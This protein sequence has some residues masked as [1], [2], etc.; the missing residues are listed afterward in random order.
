MLNLGFSEIFLIMAVA[1]VVIG[2][3]RLPEVLRFMGRQYG[4]LTRASNELR[5]AF[6]MEAERSDIEKRADALRKRREEARKRIADQRERT[7]LAAQEDTSVTP[8]I[9]PVGRTRLPHGH[10]PPIPEADAPA[11]AGQE[12]VAGAIPAS[13]PA[14]TP[15]AAPEVATA[16]PEAASSPTAHG[17]ESE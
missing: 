17:A 2:P 14:Q 11:D 8:E 12:P 10:M 1:L 16:A 15:S 7:R 9:A 13:A 4:K 3:D 6:M 5:R